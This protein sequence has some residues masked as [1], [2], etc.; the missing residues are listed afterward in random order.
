VTP[1][2]RHDACLGKEV[3][4]TPE[5]FVQGGGVRA[6]LVC[7]VDIVVYKVSRWRGSLPTRQFLRYSLE[8]DGSRGARELCMVW[9]TGAGSAFPDWC[10]ELDMA[11]IV[12]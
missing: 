3:L 5:D 11:D 12:T 10:P 7:R 6:E 8:R 1:F 4:H 9:N 2:K